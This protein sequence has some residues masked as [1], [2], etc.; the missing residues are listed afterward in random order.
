VILVLGGQGQL[1]TELALRAEEAGVPLVATGH[2]EIDVADPRTIARAAAKYRPTLIVNCAAFNNVD[3]AEKQPAQAQR[4]NALGASV[5]AAS[6][7]RAGVPIIHISTD[8]VF[9]G[10][11]PT[12]YVEDD[13]VSPLN[14]Y[15]RSKEKGEEGVRNGHAQ[16]LI[17]RTSWLYGI[18]GANFVK[19]VVRLAA[20]RDKLGFVAAQRGTPT[21]TPE[22]AKAILTAA[23][24]IAD[25][26]QP[27]G[28]YHVAGKGTVSRH[29]MATA[30]VAAQA[31]FTG[32]NPPVEVI[33]PAPDAAPRPAN[34]SLD[35][36]KFAATF[37]YA[38][39]DWQPAIEHTVNL[40]F[41]RQ[42][43]I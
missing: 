4:A 43:R 20:E 15:G 30:V 1:G 38:P 18:H 29:G 36:S 24:A 13:P 25:G 7:K 34:S 12:P 41:A 28:T 39:G 2:A 14:T 33:A 31:R 32:R 37:G 10:E 17:L 21:S 16:H 40:L 42:G 9:D 8:Y 23:R 3:A 22:L 27:W 11:K 26:A 19:T 35:S 6:A 5:A